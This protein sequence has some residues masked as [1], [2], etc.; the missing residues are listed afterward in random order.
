MG[1]RSWLL[2]RDGGVRRTLWAQLT[3]RF[4]PDVVLARAAPT[5]TPA[6]PATPMAVDEVVL[7]R[8]DQIPA[9]GV[10][11][12]MLGDVPVAV[13]RVGDEVFVVDN[14]CPH[15]GGPLGDGDLDGHLLACPF[16]GWTFDVRT[17]V[18]TVVPSKRVAVHAA[19]VVDGAVR[20]ARVAAPAA[21]R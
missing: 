13:C 21:S 5:P 8:L 18:C 12:A 3:G 1:L 10:T 4:D 14:T 9:S 11:E 7:L 17:G 16:H 15:A 20:V 2:G 19:R 6:A